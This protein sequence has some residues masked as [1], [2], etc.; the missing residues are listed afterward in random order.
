MN[1]M[2]KRVAQVLAGVV[3]LASVATAGVAMAANGDGSGSS[4]SAG[5]APA[6]VSTDE[7]GGHEGRG[8]VE[9]ATTTAGTPSRARTTGS[10]HA[11]RRRPR[12]AR[13]TSPATT[14]GVT[15]RARVRTT[16]ATTAAPAATTRAA[17]R[18]LRPGGND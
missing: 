17:R 11:E 10:H 6:V 14:T 12:P 1:T 5:K 9:R 8:E 7:R 2:K 16:T 13:E 15:T 4:P 3:G 18:Q